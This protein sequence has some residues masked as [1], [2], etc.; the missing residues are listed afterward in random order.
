M[1]KTLT[2][3]VAEPFV[4]DIGQTI[5]PGDRVA[6]F[7]HGYSI[8]FRK[9]WFDGVFKDERGDVVFTRVRGIHTEK[10]V[11]TGKM[12]KGESVRWNYETRGY[13][14]YTYEY[15][16]Y[17]RVQVEPHGTTVLQRHRIA[18]IED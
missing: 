6:Y 16:E 1:G 4:N 9:G 7:A 11:L 14:P 18:K 15:P 8:T 13:E 2:T 12:L 5:N 3:F 10:S 17:E